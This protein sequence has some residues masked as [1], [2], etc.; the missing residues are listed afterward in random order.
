[1]PKR[2]VASPLVAAPILIAIVSIVIVSAQRN[3]GILVYALDDAYIHLAVAK[4]LVSHFTWGVNPGEFSSPTS[5]LLWPVIL[6]I[7]ASWHIGEYLPLILNVSCA[8]LLTLSIRRTLLESL[9]DGLANILAAILPFFCFVPAIALSGMEHLTHAVLVVMMFG[10]VKNAKEP[11]WKLILLSL[12]LGAVRYEGVLAI[13]LATVWLSWNRQWRPALAVFAGG[14]MPMV[15]FGVVSLENGWEFFPNSVL[16]KSGS[17]TL[18][19]RLNWN[20]VSSWPLG[21]P[22]LLALAI[23]PLLG[24][25]V[26][27]QRKVTKAVYWA[28]CFILLL[29]GHLS[30]RAIPSTSALSIYRYEV[31]LLPLGYLSVIFLLQELWSSGKL[32]NR[33]IILPSCVLLVYLFTTKNLFARAYGEMRNAIVA[34]N[35]IY[36]QQWQ[37]ANV[38]SKLPVGRIA[39]NDLGVMAYHSNHSVMDAFGLADQDVRKAKQS[40][41]YSTAMLDI[42]S[43]QKDVRYAVLYEPPNFELIGQVPSQWELAGSWHYRNTYVL[44]GDRV[45]FYALNESDLSSISSILSDFRTRN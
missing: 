4:N 31:Y 26:W 27:R 6:A 14:L 17:A 11:T 1:M 35:E 25:I 9:T 28:T 12:L 7:A 44:G 18:I 43:K 10:S 42:L 38:V 8:L 15:V 2:S 16:L 36:S 5:S 34:S 3:G 41:Q 30:G 39:V 32:L 20:I 37:M 40:G 21:T 22:Q 13:L 19:Q 23:L 45:N 33:L 24:F 29:L